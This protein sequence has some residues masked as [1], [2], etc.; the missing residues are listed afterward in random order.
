M[1]S[2]TADDEVATGSSVPETGGPEKPGVSVL[3][4]TYNQ[5]DYVGD[6]ISAILVQ[7]APPFEVIIADDCSVD[8]TWNRINAAVMGY[9]GPN[10]VQLVRNE[11]NL[12]INRNLNRMI[13]M[14][15]GEIL[16]VAAGDDISVPE[17][18]RR[19]TETFAR[20]RP[21]LVHSGFV[22]LL[23]PGQTYDGLYDN[24]IF[25]RTTDPVQIAG[26]TALFVGATAAWHRD[27][28]RIFGP[29]PDGP[30]YEDLILGFR[31]ALAGRVAMIDAPLVQYRIGT[32]VSSKRL[33]N[34]THSGWRTYRLSALRG[35]A[36]MLM[37]RRAD[38]RAYGASEDGAVVRAIDRSIL[39][40]RMQMDYWLMSTTE[41]FKNHWLHPLLAL[42][43][44]RSERRRARLGLMRRNA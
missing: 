22:P 6:A 39:S 43:R 31:A 23:P 24:L 25:T 40:N 28:F 12:G 1:R 27:L 41:F 17:R 30:V 5:Q 15:G 38:A 18:V 2:C 44:W 19:V 35:H 9:A 26:S 21:L 8:A 37:Q 7:D 32:G 11:V 33:Q 13:E 42:R 36:E 10:R 16:I 14:A 34:R 3:I 4:P 20:E 29:L